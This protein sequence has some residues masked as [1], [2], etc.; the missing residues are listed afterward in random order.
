MGP[1]SPTTM[2]PTAM[3]S[4]GATGPSIPPTRSC[5]ASSWIHCPPAPMTSRVRP[6]AKRDQ[7]VDG[8]AKVGDLTP[9]PAGLRLPELPRELPVGEDIEHPA[10][11]VSARDM[12]GEH[13][14]GDRGHDAPEVVEVV[15]RGD[16]AT[17]GAAEDE[18]LSSGHPR[19]HVLR[20]MPDVDR[21]ARG[22]HEGEGNRAA[23]GLDQDKL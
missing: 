23:V 6:V 3:S 8:S 1:L 14:V 13:R 9:A 15:R 5:C 19:L 16:R 7:P 4:A 21:L 22:R 10:R 11:E 18:A 17:V 12:L 2:V 20:E